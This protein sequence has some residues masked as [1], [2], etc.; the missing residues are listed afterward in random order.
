VANLPLALPGTLGEQLARIVDVEG[1]IPRA[2]DA[3][4]PVAGRDVLLIASDD[5]R[6]AAQLTELGARVVPIDRIDEPEV[7]AASADVVVSLG[8]AFRGPDAAELMADAAAADRLLRPS[9]RLVVIHDYGR[10]DVSR[11]RGDLPEYG[12][13]TRR[14]GPFLRGGFRIRVLHCWWTFDSLD[15]AREFLAR[16]F[17]AIGETVAAE[18]H[19]PR[20]SYN[21]ALYHRDRPAAPQRGSTSGRLQSPA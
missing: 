6:C 11:L 15:D 20:L 18:L 16:A 10:D 4:A 8:T 3:L 21:V 7:A 1:K 5:G 19:R 12:L 17:G 2:I 9:G 13:W 14:D